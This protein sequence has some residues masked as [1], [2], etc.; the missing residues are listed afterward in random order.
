MARG[1][2]TRDTPG[3]VAMCILPFILPGFCYYHPASRTTEAFTATHQFKV[4]PCS[5]NGELTTT[6]VYAG[7]LNG[8][9]VEQA[10]PRGGIDKNKVMRKETA[11]DLLIGMPAMAQCPPRHKRRLR[12]AVKRNYDIYSFREQAQEATTTE[13]SPKCSPAVSTSFVR[14]SLLGRLSPPAASS[15]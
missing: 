12:S 10:R 5:S 14:T 11:V 7:L 3:M 2:G 1:H 9:T 4:R 8:I 6:T 13:M 15:A